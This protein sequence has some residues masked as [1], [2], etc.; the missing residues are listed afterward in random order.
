MLVG[1]FWRRVTP[2]T[3]ARPS[4]AGSSTSSPGWGSS[5]TCRTPGARRPVAAAGV[6]V[7]PDLRRPA[8]ARAAR[9][10]L[11]AR[12]GDGGLARGRRALAAQ[13]GVAPPRAGGHDQPARER[14][15]P[16]PDDA[17]PDYRT[18]VN[19]PEPQLALE[20]TA[21]GASRSQ[22]FPDIIVVEHPRY[23]PIM[24]A[25]VETK[26]TV[27]RRQAELVWAQLENDDAPL[28]I[29]VPSGSRPAPATTRSPRASSTPAS[30][31]GVASR[32]GCSSGSSSR[33]FT[34]KACQRSNLLARSH[35]DVPQ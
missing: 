10:R 17:H 25:Q 11:E 8:G 34:G 24:V 20:F 13:R 27:T 29:Y 16:V 32:A 6:A 7:P 26:E 21:G 31:P 30:A 15:L 35:R 23:R 19:V 5:R 33:R 4:S 12:A 14:P 3:A 2:S 18:Y 1:P 9:L 22:V 28:Y